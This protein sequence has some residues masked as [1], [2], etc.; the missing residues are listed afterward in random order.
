MR[1]R[2]RTGL[3]DALSGNGYFVRPARG[4]TQNQRGGDE[5]T[6][7]K[8]IGIFMSARQSRRRSTIGMGW[9]QLLKLYFRGFAGRSEDRRVAQVLK[10]VKT[11]VL[12]AF[13]RDTP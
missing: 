3:D 11:S 6:R 2:S 8:R 9:T 5:A 10:L 12:P 7:P 1:L 4:L 13:M